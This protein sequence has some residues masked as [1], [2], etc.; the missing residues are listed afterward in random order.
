MT[1]PRTATR[2]EVGAPASPPPASPTLASPTMAFPT[3]A[4]P[5]LAPTRFVAALA[6]AAALGLVACRSERP[7][8]PASQTGDT[9]AATAEAGAGDDGAEATERA[10]T[11]EPPVPTA[12]HPPMAAPDDA[13]LPAPDEIPDFLAPEGEAAPRDARSPF[14]A[15]DGPA[16]GPGAAPSLDVAVPLRDDALT[17]Y[18]PGTGGSTPTPDVPLEALM[19]Q[20]RLDED[21]DDEGS[22]A[23]VISTD[24]A[25]GN[26][27]GGAAPAGRPDGSPPAA[28]ARAPSATGEEI[29]E[30]TPE[31]E[32][33]EDDGADWDV[34]LALDGGEP[35]ACARLEG[36]I[37]AR[38]AFLRRVAAERD[39][40]AWVE[41][42]EDATALRLIA[43]M[44]R[45][46]EFP[47]DEDCR[48]PPMEVDLRAV[49]PP[50][51]Q[52]ERW[53]SDLEAEHKDPDDVPND[54][55]I[56][57]LRHQ[58]DLCRRKQSPQPLLDRGGR[59]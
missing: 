38:M 7:A 49:E 16:D 42:D 36:E 3:L 56:R 27:P 30:E 8:A 18:D 10:T 24:D 11:K 37:D 34:D 22:F 6:I 2:T 55:G 26:R 9:R 31:A 15:G 58:L 41:S 43:A 25:G 44:R 39:T 57:E 12:A 21:G 5:T 40:Y 13:P 50:R 48:P 54:P 17:G 4:S 1:T 19:R 51:H 28:W 45:C 20:V 29:A 59:Y 53:P 14:A 47:E 46:A 35:D 32:N 23:S 52:F 33:S